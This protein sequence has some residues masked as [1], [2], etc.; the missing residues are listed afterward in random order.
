MK[1]FTE[2]SK[3]SR[4]VGLRMLSKMR[5]KGLFEENIK[6]IFK[7]LFEID[8]SVTELFKIDLRNACFRN[9]NLEDTLF[10]SADLRDTFWTGKELNLK[11]TDFTGADLRGANLRR[12]NLS[13]SELGIAKYDEDTKFPGGFSEE[14]KNTMVF[15]P[16]EKEYKK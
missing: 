3:P 5:R 4:V 1:L 12:T 10:N 11:G 15:V 8:L 2:E 16:K 9:A 14:V 13:L 6:E 7:H